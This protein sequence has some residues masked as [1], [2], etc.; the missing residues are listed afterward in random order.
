MVAHRGIL[1]LVALCILPITVR[2]QAVSASA[3][4]GALSYPLVKIPA[5]VPLPDLPLLEDNVTLVL[6]ASQIQ[7]QHAVSTIVACQLLRPFTF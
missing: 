2:S 7:V 1:A 4:P 3:R 5:R 6:T